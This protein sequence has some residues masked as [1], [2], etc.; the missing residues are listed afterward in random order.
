MAGERDVAG[1]NGVWGRGWRGPLSGLLDL[2]FPPLCHQCRGFI[3]HAGR[4]HVC[5]ACLATSR[6]VEPPLCTICGVPFPA[7]A[8]IDHPCGPCLTTPPPFAAARAAF[9]Y[10]GA[11]RDLI[12]RFKY[13]G[14]VQVR[15]P[16]ALLM[17]DRL[18]PLAAEKA[19]DLLVPVPLHVRR[20]RQRGF[21]QAVLLGALLSREW[22]IPLGRR[23]LRRIRWTEPQ[24]NLAAKERLANVRGAFAVTDRARVEGKRVMLVDDVLT[25][26]STLAECS[27]VLLRAGAAEVCAVTIARVAWD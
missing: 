19:P 13:D 26:G 22:Q 21:N 18:A 8:G 9:L 1:G 16:L 10:E 6:P 24:V 15:R 23:A 25:T 20:L 3:P 12:H 5:P 4:V 14:A 11:I 7:P 27:R 2:F 17:A